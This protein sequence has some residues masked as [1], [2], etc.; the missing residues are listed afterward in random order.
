MNLSNEQFG[1]WTKLGIYVKKEGCNG[2]IALHAPGRLIAMLMQTSNFDQA[3]AAIKKL[4]KITVTEDVTNGTVTFTVTF[5][6]WA[7]YQKD[8]SRERVARFREL[9]SSKNESSNPDT[10]DN[11]VTGN[12]TVGGT[13]TN[14]T[15]LISTSSSYKKGVKEG[16]G[17]PS[18]GNGNIPFQEIIDHLNKTAGK[19]YRLTLSVKE[20]IAARFKEGATLENF[21]YVHENKTRH[22]KGTENEIYLRP[23][24]LYR[25]SKFESYRNEPYIRAYGKH[26]TKSVKHVS[27]FEGEGDD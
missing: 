27:D 20:A 7:K 5:R 24:T 11:H 25:P 26:D 12:V 10:S 4:P 17:K 3:I 9:H 23:E 18:E 6:N 2:S 14:V 16:S 21:K 15:P 1:Q 19:T 13:V 8:N 22:W